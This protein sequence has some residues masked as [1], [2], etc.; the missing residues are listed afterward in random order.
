MSKSAFESCLS[1]A[2]ARFLRLKYRKTIGFSSQDETAKVCAL[3]AWLSFCLLTQNEIPEYLHAIPASE[4]EPEIRSQSL[5]YTGQGLQS[6]GKGV[7]S[8]C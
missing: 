7:G 8:M 6:S 1:L 5:S 4:T 3:N 2:P